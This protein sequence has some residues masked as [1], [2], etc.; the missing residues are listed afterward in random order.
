MKR[1]WKVNLDYEIELFK[2][3]SSFQLEVKSDLE[4]LFF[5]YKQYNQDFLITDIE[6]SSEYI[7]YLNDLGLITNT[8][9]EGAINIEN[10]YGSLKDIELE[11]Q[12][13][14]KIK[15]LEILEKLCLAP[16][17]YEFINNKEQFS[18]LTPKNHFFFKSPYLMSG[19]NSGRAHLN[20]PLHYP[21]IVEPYYKKIIDVSFY[22][23]SETK[24]G[25]YYLC[26]TSK[27]GAYLGGVVFQQQKDFFKY[28]HKYKS[29]ET[30]RTKTNILI[31]Y[32]ETL[33]LKQN[34]SI[35]SF[36]YDKEELYFCSDINYRRNMGELLNQLK[37]FLPMNGVGELILT[38]KNVPRSL[39]Y[40]RKA[41]TGTIY[42]SPKNGSSQLI[43]LCGNNILEIKKTK[44]LLAIS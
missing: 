25:E 8:I 31:Q 27:D 43:F 1:Y 29:I 38:N 41:K 42:M 18:E 35:D 26:S 10:W 40:N 13:N 3:E 30:L 39:K 44:Y 32:L 22:Y 34:L 4:C 33:P 28:L 5:F 9:T 19:I 2:D 14:S 24:T 23:N 37:S 6:Y 12:L 17:S 21:I 36:I 20:N 7:E 15:M 16:S 11:K